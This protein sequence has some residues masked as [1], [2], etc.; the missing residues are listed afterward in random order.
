[1]SKKIA[2]FGRLFT[3]FASHNLL[4]TNDKVGDLKWQFVFP[5]KDERKKFDGLLSDLDSNPLAYETNYVQI[6]IENVFKEKDK[7]KL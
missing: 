7:K 2:I 5:N 4:F 6:T 3:T 1:M